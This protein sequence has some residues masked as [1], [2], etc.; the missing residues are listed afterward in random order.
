MT[1]QI[2]NIA[3]CPHC[4]NRAPQSL[5]HRQYYSEKAW[6]SEHEQ[7]SEDIP[8]SSFV[9]SC[10]TCQKII[11][12]DNP[13]NTIFDNEFS[14]GELVYPNIPFL[15]H[16]VPEKVVNAYAEASRIKEISPNGFAVLIRRTL[17]ILCNEFG[18]PDGTLVNRIRG[19]S[20]TGRLPPILL[21]AADLL[22]LVGNIGAHSSEKSVH[23]LHVSAI[24]EFFLAVIEY[25]YIAPQKIAG[26]QKRLAALEAA[27]DLDTPLPEEIPF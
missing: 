1:G 22:R 20:D 24:D 21:Q 5:I 12:Y 18:I 15:Y 10:G 13:G 3:F 6:E 27:C 11:V 16:F 9:A 19:L 25:L 7:R 8:W 23:P 4:G 17:E 14:R 26:F 2:T